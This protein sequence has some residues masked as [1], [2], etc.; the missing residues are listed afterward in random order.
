MPHRAVVALP[1]LVFE[2]NNLLVL[3][4]FDD[5]GGNF[6]A[7]NGTAVRHMVAIREHEHV[8][9]R[10]GFARFDIQKIDINRIAFCDTILAPT[11]FDNC[12]SHKRE[13]VS[14]GESREKFHTSGGLT[15]GKL[16][17]L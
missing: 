8:T 4:V 2:R 17:W 6:G 10:G 13:C 3:A 16:G 15:S 9:Q 5:F 1:A 7:F 11:G 12:V 14:R